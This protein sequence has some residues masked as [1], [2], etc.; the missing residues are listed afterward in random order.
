MRSARLFR[1]E[2]KPSEAAKA[3]WFSVTDPTVMRA[4]ASVPAKSSSE[5]LDFCWT[6]GS[7]SP[8]SRSNLY[9]QT[10]FLCVTFAG[11]ASPDVSRFLSPVTHFSRSAVGSPVAGFT[12][13]PS[14][15]YV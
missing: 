5:M 14:W 8:V 7:T 15:L 11:S 10:T 2:L 12:S 4:P 6:V 13:T 9:R 3:S 1:S